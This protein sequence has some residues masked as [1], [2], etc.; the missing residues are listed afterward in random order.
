M[1]FV[2]AEKFVRTHLPSLP[3][4]ARL[5]RCLRLS[6]VSLS[7]VAEDHPTVPNS[8]NLLLLIQFY[9]YC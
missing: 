5:I 2:I 6:G 1:G 3:A 9:M 4:V 7:R 8:G